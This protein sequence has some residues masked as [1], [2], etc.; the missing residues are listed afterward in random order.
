M[1]LTYSQS[2]KFGEAASDFKLQGIDGK[3]Y[4]LDSFLAAKVLVV[5]FMCNHCPY[6]K[7]CWQ[8]LVDLQS[9]FEKEGVQFVGINSND[10]TM[11][12]DDS[13][14]KMQ[15]YATQH[16]QNFPYLQDKTQTV[17]KAYGATCTPDI[18]VYDRSRALQYHGRIDD[19]WKDHTM[20]T[21]HELADA[22]AALV[23]GKKPSHEQQ[24]SM[25]CSIKWKEE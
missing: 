2:I 13:F 15:E 12:P 17:A 18:F 11:Y 19:N 3:T 22:L 14:E 23:A 8:R 16:K 6:V 25:G 10:E 24:P 20:V 7:A 21:K 5:V 4:T 9:E 1:A